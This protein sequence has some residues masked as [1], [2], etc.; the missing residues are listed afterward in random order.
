[1]ISVLPAALLLLSIDF[2][3]VPA[4]VRA[5]DDN[6]TRMKVNIWVDSFEM[7][8][9]ETTQQEYRAVMG[10]NPSAHQ[11]SDLPVENVSWF[12]AIRF[13]NRY[14]LRRGVEPCYNLMTGERAR[15]SCSGYR[16]PTEAEWESVFGER[17]TSGASNLGLDQT[18]DPAPLAGLRTRVVDRTPGGIR[19]LS[20]NVWEWCEDWFRSSPSPWPIHNPSG[21]LRGLARVIRGGSYLTTR[22]SWAGR[23]R[24]SLDP[25]AR[26]P[27]TGFRLVRSTGAIGALQYTL[28]P[29]EP[30]L[31][32]HPGPEPLTARPSPKKWLDVMGEPKNLSRKLPPKVRLVRPFEDSYYGGRI[33]E[34]E[35]EPG[36][37]TKFAIL[38]GTPNTSVIEKRPVVI[39]PYYDID[40]PLG[41]ELG[42]RSFNPAPAVWFARHAAQLGFIAIAVRWFGENDSERYDEAVA[43]LSRRH[44]GLTGLGKWVW[45][46]KRLIDY[47]ETMPG[48][49]R[50]RI[51]MIGHSLGGKMTLYA[52]AFDPRIR[53]AVA[54]EPGIAFGF[55]NYGDYWYWGN[56]LAQLPAGTDQHELLG[57]IAPRP[58]LLIAGEDSDGDKSWPY[59]EAARPLYREDGYALRWINHRK[60]H[61]PTLEATAQA[62]EW[63][64]SA[65]TR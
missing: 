21:P 40:T 29:P 63:L 46:A 37:W 45:D 34:Y 51:G 55:S 28:D 25:K 19:D 8:R 5:V 36:L 30:P 56:R 7:S 17:D 35:S 4:S 20:G 38:D 47:V 57:L 14:S 43:D 26:S 53:A 52:T 31:R 16:L 42:G 48:V 27:H 1:M 54:S 61:T 6:V 41:L 18:T 62:M 32:I 24:S 64:S 49:D 33:L 11:G 15:R 9:Q 60:G 39:V 12:D 58:F 13:A 65:L 50:N 2:V 10:S 44:A 59:L 23:Y 3:N 22:S